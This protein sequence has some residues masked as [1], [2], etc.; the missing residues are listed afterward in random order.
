MNISI[1][2]YS[3]YPNIGGMEEAIRNLAREFTAKGN[4]VN[5]IV[6]ATDRELKTYEVLEGIEVYRFFM[7]FAILPEKGLRGIIDILKLTFSLPVFIPRLTRLL[8]KIKTQIIYVQFI[9]IN[10]FYAWVISYLLPIKFIITLQ[11]FNFQVIPFIKGWRSILINIFCRRLLTRASYVT[12][13]SKFLLDDAIKIVP[14]I[15]NKSCVIPNG[16]NLKEFEYNGRALIEG[17]YILCLGRLH[18][19]FKGFD[20]ALFAFKDIIDCGYNMDLVLAGE[21]PSEKYYQK[22][23]KLLGIS[24]RVLFFGKAD[25]RQVV[26]L[27]K[28]CQFFLMPSRIEPFGIVNLEAMAAG[29][30]ILASRTGGIPEVVGDNISGILVEQANTKALFLGIRKM[31]EDKDLRHRLGRQGRHKIEEGQFLWSNIADRYLKKF[32]QV[33]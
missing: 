6:F 27:F 25:R 22:L 11:G 20:L 31:L 3:Y 29:K 7:P 30:A 24:E 1:F 33:V 28:H 19:P 5:I 12:S 16:I 32:K 14:Q 15:N 8:K 9:A 4:K 10:A 18:A 2:T 21:G 26:N 13:C 17:P 23:A